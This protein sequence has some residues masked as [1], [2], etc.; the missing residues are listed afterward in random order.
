MRTIAAL[1]LACLLAD[2]AAMGRRAV[3]I[4]T[5]VAAAAS[6]N[7]AVVTIDRAFLEAYRN[8]V[9]I[10]AT[11]TVDDAMRSPNPGFL[12]GDL[13]LAGRAPEIGLR[14]VAEIMNASSESLAVARVNQ[15]ES[16]RA[17]LQL[18]GV[19]RL[20]PEHA[21]GPE[22]QG[23]RVPQLSDPNPDHIF[24]LHPVIEVAGINLL[25]TLRPVEDYHP[26]SAKKTFG[27]YE[28][29]D[30][31]LKV[32]PT[33]VAFITSTW[34]YN[35]VH[36]LMQLSDGPQLVADGGR[37]VT[38][39]ALDL[40]G[41]LLVDSL[42]MV[43]VKDSPPERAVRALKPGARLEV[44][45]LPRVSFAE[46][47]RRIGAAPTNPAELKGKLPYEIIVLGMYQEGK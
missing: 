19:W 9:T 45:G 3:V 14:L 11:F 23:E 12:D 7:Q 17:P 4:Y 42:R 39:S 37:F 40:D 21:I 28:G 32:T 29:A 44:W 13:H 8:R 5:T 41:N 15:A 1:S 24:E 10:A 34:L 25:R 31:T 38:A 43:L 2:C 18:T 35:D 16:T 26:G 27:I 6:P 20:W 22:E 46:I 30:C 36:F 33:T 47:S